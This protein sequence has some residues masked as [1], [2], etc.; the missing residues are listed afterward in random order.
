MTKCKQC[1][2]RVWFWQGKR[3]VIE[4]ID[5][6]EQILKHRVFYYHAACVPSHYSVI[7]YSVGMAGARHN[8]QWQHEAYTVQLGKGRID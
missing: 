1:G 6:T 2:K 3:K 4:P 5:A 7:P 8:I